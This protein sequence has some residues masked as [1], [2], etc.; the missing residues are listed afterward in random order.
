MPEFFFSF[1]KT[2]L[3]IVVIMMMA[4][5]FFWTRHRLKTPS[6][7]FYFSSLDN[8]SLPIGWRERL[9]L[10]P[11]RLLQLSLAC[12]LLAFIDPHLLV[13][14]QPFSSSEEKAPT[15]GIGI[16]LVLDQSGS[17][18]EEI[19]AASES[20]DREMISKMALLKKVTK[21]FIEKDSSNL[22]GLISFA[23]IPQVIAPLTLDHNALLKDIDQLT[24]IPN[25]A[26]DGTS[27]GYA[28]FKTANLIANTKY[29]A[30]EL[31]K[32]N[33]LPYEIK[34]TILILVTDGFQDPN[35]LD[36]GNRLRTM[37][38]NDAAQFAK[39]QGIRLYII[40]VDPKIK[41]ETFA[42]HRRLL[43]QITEE[44]GGKFFVADDST[45][46][47]EIY[48][49]IN[50]LEKSDIPYLHKSAQDYQR[51]SFFP[52]LIAFGML[53]LISAIVLETTFLRRAP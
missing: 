36:T 10:I 47:K 21:E 26:Y 16:Y 50:T 44:T 8:L 29:I 14:R 19:W 35:P 9:V 5:F 6:S 39:E 38:L 4:L 28:I 20:K 46:L 34:N 31:K 12:F 3:L 22:I 41:N 33:Q 11:K 25:A 37:S 1:D 51:V 49:A 18:K 15:Q 2:A 7:Y 27:M 23:R 45:S 32:K 30:E 17:M 43:N 40:N 52:F 13:D 53:C 42:P 24:V 48:D